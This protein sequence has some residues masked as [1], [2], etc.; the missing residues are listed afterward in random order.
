MK[1]RPCTT[2]E[3]LK[4]K[5]IVPP[6]TISLSAEVPLTV[7][8]LGWTLLGSTG[9]NTLTTK[10]VSCAETVLPQGGWL[11][12]TEQGASL[13]VGIGLEVAV[14]VA[15]A[16]GVTIGVAVAVAVPVAVGV[17]TGVAVAVAVA[18]AV[19]VTTGVAVAVAVAVGVEVAVGVG[20]GVPPPGTRNAYTLLSFA[21]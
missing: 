20:V 15:V 4:W 21:T 2:G 7:K 17:T 10:S 1:F 3:A 14:A 12:I 16:V 11:P 9:A 19:G 8:S 5:V 6:P 13:G 18:V